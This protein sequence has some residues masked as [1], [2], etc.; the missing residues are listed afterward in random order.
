MSIKNISHQLYDAKNRFNEMFDADPN[1][2]HYNKHMHSLING[3]S[4]ELSEIATELSWRDWKIEQLNQQLNKSKEDIVR[5]EKY[6][7][8]LPYQ[9]IMLIINEMF[10]KR[11][12]DPKPISDSKLNKEEIAKLF[13][14]I[15]YN[16]VLEI[17]IE[18]LTE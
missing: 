10:D 2:K 8:Q 15:F 12:Y 9:E 1:L 11:Q 6:I 4:G 17:G 18:R 13:G 16:K 3:E 5:L 7:N 14:L